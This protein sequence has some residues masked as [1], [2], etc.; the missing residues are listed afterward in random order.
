M[1]SLE[2][3]YIQLFQQCNTI[4]NEQS[5]KEID[6]VVDLI[7]DTQLNYTCSV[8]EFRTEGLADQTSLLLYL[9]YI[10]HAATSSPSQNIILSTNVL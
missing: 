1:N 10:R 7:Y 5:Q 2:N 6:P 9:V 4:V 8:F 3:F